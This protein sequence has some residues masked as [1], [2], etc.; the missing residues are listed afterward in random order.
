MQQI[1]KSE[2]DDGNWSGFGVISK[3]FL[4]DN[5]SGDMGLEERLCISFTLFYLDSSS[6]V[7][8]LD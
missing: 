7:L 1:F 3:G 8:R 2:P 4:L 6:S 5:K